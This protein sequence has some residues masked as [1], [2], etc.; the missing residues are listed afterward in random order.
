MWEFTCT[1]VLYNLYFQT[2]WWERRQKVYKK[3]LEP[4]LQ[5]PARCSGTHHLA[6]LEQSLAPSSSSPPLSQRSATSLYQATSSD[7][8]LSACWEC[9]SSVKQPLKVFK[10]ITKGRWENTSGRV[11]NR[12]GEEKAS[13]LLLPW[14]EKQAL[15]SKICSKKWTCLQETEEH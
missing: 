5:L 3:S 11:I 7:Y 6:L 4:L 2:Y 12:D 1:I 13:S 15:K 14:R 10:E 8:K 9:L